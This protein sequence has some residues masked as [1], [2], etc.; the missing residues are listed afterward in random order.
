MRNKPNQSSM[1]IDSIN[2]EQLIISDQV[3]ITNEF[4]KYFS[5]ID[6]CKAEAFHKVD[7]DFSE[8]LPPPLHAYFTNEPVEIMEELERLIN[9]TSEEINGVSGN[10]LKIYH[11]K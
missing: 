10:C 8:F 7:N 2:K 11:L 6:Q 1:K 3:L 4:N 5:S 9:K